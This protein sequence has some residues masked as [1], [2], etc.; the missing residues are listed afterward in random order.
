[1]K[2]TRAAVNTNRREKTTTAERKEKNESESDR[3]P[4]G[5]VGIQQFVK[6]QYECIK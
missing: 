1:V 6:M 5:V 4:L 3:D 2:T